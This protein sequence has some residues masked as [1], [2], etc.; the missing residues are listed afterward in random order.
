MTRFWMT[1]SQGVEFVIKTFHRMKG[2][3]IFIPKIPSIFIK[4]LIK[5]FNP[6]Y[7]PKIIGIRPGEKLEETLCAKEDSISTYDFGDHYEI[8]SSISYNKINKPINRLKEIGKKVSSD[9]EYTSNNN[10]NFLSI[11]Q[12]RKLNSIK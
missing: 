11:D 7:K 9:F 5:S 6:N 2:G 10:K 12:I 4:D 3:E 8:L 1:L